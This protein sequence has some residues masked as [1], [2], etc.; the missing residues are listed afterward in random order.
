MEIEIKTEYIKLEQLL[1]YA[2]LVETGGMAKQAIQEGLVLLNGE[3]EVRR[4]KK[5]Y[6]G[7]IVKFN[8]EEIR[9]K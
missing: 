3:V 6:K 9:V 1:K 7:D 2:N 8:N 4:G 5:I